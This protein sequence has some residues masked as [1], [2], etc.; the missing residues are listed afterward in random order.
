MFERN[1]DV[2]YICYDNEGYMNTGVQRSSATPP[3]ARTA[4]TPALG[5]A[6]GNVFGTGKNLPLIAMAHNIPY[7]ATASVADLHDLEAKVTKAMGIA[8]ARYIHIM[9]P[10]PLG[11]G[12]ASHDTIKLARL[13]RETGLFPVFEAEHGEITGVTPIRRR[14]PVDE[15]LKPQKRF[16]HLFG[17]NAHADMLAQ[18][19]ADADRNIR[20][21]KLLEEDRVT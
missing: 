15:Y 1:D 16:A 18:I 12:S 14:V 20:R 13:A 6:P 2:L 7:V 4:T 10:C 5:E 3:A 21:F 8:G 19:Q 11:W 9:V 17:A